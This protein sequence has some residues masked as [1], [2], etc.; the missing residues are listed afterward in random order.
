MFSKSEAGFVGPA[1]GRGHKSR[2]PPLLP[3]E[4]PGR[5]AC[6]L[7]DATSWNATAHDH[8]EISHV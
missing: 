6:S 8:T 3:E 5:A 4:C 2:R 1:G 7:G